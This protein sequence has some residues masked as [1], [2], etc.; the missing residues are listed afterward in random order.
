MPINDKGKFDGKVKDGD[1]KVLVEGEVKQGG[2]QGQGHHPREGRLRR[3]AE[4]CNSGKVKWEA[5]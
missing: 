3:G 2:A 5:S 4:G 1:A